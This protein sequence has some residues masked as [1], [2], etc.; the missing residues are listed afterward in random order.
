METKK[1]KAVQEPIKGR[2]YREK[3]NSQR[4]YE[5]WEFTGKTMESTNGKLYAFSNDRG[6]EWFDTKDIKGLIKQPAAQR[7]HVSRSTSCAKQPV[8]ST[9]PKSAAK[10]SQ[11]PAKTKT[12]TVMAGGKSRTFATKKEAKAYE[13]ACRK[14]AGKPYAIKESTRK[15]TH[16]IVSFTAK[17]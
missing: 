11:L 13:Q 16:R 2:T 4:G 10:T 12:Y 7:G 6:V 1:S 3:V 14:R 17:K 5:D 9:A 15:P 8:K